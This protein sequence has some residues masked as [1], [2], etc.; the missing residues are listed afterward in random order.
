VTGQEA[1]EK[2]GTRVQP[3]NSLEDFSCNMVKKPK[4]MTVKRS[5]TPRERIF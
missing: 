3:G 1:W 4:I 2:R 5:P